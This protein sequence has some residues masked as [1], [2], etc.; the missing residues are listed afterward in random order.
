MSKEPVRYVHI[1][2]DHLAIIKDNLLSYEIEPL[3]SALVEYGMN[4]TLPDK[5]DMSQAAYII[6]CFIALEMEDYTR[7][8]ECS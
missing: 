8:K 7:K 1:R 4:G 2:A 3:L 5:N 6:F